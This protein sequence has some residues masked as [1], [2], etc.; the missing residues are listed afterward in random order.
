MQGKNSRFAKFL[1]LCRE[2]KL[3]INT[4]HC[5]DIPKHE[6]EQLRLICDLKKL[7]KEMRENYFNQ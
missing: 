4:C 2:N 3:F 6:N 1:R 7:G 5:L